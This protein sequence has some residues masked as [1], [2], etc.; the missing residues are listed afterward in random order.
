MVSMPCRQLLLQ[1][2]HACINLRARIAL[3]PHA[4]HQ[5]YSVYIATAVAECKTAVLDIS[6]AESKPRSRRNARNR[7]TSNPPGTKLFYNCVIIFY[8][9]HTSC[10]KDSVSLALAGS[11]LSPVSPS[12]EPALWRQNNKKKTHQKTHVHTRGVGI[13]HRDVSGTHVQTGEVSV[14]HRTI[15]PRGVEGQ[16]VG[17]MGKRFNAFFLVQR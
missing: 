16:P 13:A 11:T 4:V 12:L 17:Q 5:I 9:V 15:S 6:P 2:P 3:T 10:R 8:R 7:C 1:V 14:A